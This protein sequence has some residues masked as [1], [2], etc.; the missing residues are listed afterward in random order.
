MGRETCLTLNLLGR[1]KKT[2]WSGV[3]QKGKR[4][5]FTTNIDEE[6]LKK[7]KVRAIKE[8]KNVNEIIEEL[9]EEYLKRWS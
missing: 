4:V 8:G 7:I 1:D 2:E 6:L 3:M 5:K 9:F